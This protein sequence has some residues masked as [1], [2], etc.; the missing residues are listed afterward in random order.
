[1]WLGIGH[2]SEIFLPKLNAYNILDL[3]DT[4][5]QLFGDKGFE[6]VGIRPGEKL[7]ET[8][9]NA[10]EIKYTWELDDKYLIFNP[11]LDDNEIKNRYAKISKVKNLTSYTS[12]TVEKIPMEDLKQ[13]ISKTLE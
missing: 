4:L 2:G 3:K 5:F 8:L 9:I 1:M 12:D 7:H 6:E 13:K 11:L 10:D